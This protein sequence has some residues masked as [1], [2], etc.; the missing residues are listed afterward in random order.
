MIN[1]YAASFMIAARTEHMI[2][3]R[4]RAARPTK[5]KGL[6]RWAAPKHW[7]ETDGNF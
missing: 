7:R 5:V 4:I 2:K 1:P 6:K 3:P